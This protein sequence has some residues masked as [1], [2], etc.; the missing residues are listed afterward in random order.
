MRAPQRPRRFRACARWIGVLA[1]CSFSCAPQEPAAPLAKRPNLLVIVADD[2]GF[3]DVGWRAEAEGGVNTPHLA[4]LAQQSLRFTNYATAPMCSP[5]RAGLLTGRNPLRM[6]LSRNVRRADRFGLPAQ[7]RTL[8]ED[9]RAAG[10]ATRLVGKWHL[11]HAEPAL[12]PLARGFEQHYG[13]LGGWIDYS[14]HRRGELHD[15][16]RD[17]ASLEEPG[18]ATHL[19]AEE[20][21]RSIRGRD[22][23]RPFLLWFAP[24]APHAPIHV[25]PGRDPDE[26]EQGDLQR[27]CYLLMVSELDRA[28]GRVLETL[29]AEGLERDTLVLFVSDNGGDPSYGAN[30]APLR[31][32]K[33]EVWEGGIRSP[34][35]LRW[36]GVVEPRDWP[37]FATFLDVAPTLA[38][39]LG[40]PLARAAELDGRDLWP[41]LQG[42]APV[43]PT[44][45]ALGSERLDE[46]RL[47]VTDGA[48]KL[49]LL[50]EK[51]SGREQRFLYALERDPGETQDALADLPEPWFQ[52]DPALALETWLALP[53]I[54][55]AR[56]E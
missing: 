55:A 45:L 28:V 49:A 54:R 33:Y 52:S 41:A 44:A 5:A 30:N 20:A 38:A 27:R 11:G 53:R 1:L 40:V 48:R 26:I 23:S 34:A 16:Q 14:T 7:E 21:V 12:Q 3:A 8:A 32:G 25:P 15:W 9:L 46:L 10:Y 36:P 19:L 43:P 47:A 18:Y 51:P 6:G 2:L 39:A 24:G 4:A 17:G 50:V 35:L 56:E 42:D 22:A 13:F 31:G 37:H 29:R